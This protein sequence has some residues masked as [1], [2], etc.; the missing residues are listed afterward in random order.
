MYQPEGEK[1]IVKLKAIDGGK[2]EKKSGPRG[3]ELKPALRAV[4]M[5]FTG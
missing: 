3:G 4:M 1:V 5:V 2:K